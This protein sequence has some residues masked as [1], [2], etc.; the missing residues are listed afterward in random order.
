MGLHQMTTKK[1]AFTTRAL[2]VLTTA[3]AD[4]NYRDA[5]LIIAALAREHGIKL[6]MR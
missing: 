5:E 2:M 6:P 3:M 1:E 4:R